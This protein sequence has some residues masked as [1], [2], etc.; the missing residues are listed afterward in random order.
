MLADETV[1]SP[2][3]TPRTTDPANAVASVLLAVDGPTWLHDVLPELTREGFHCVVDPTGESALDSDLVSAVDIAIVDLGL[4]HMSG[5]AVC[6]AFRSR[7]D[8]PIIAVV[9]VRDEGSVLDAF[10]AGADHV[11]LSDVSARQVIARMRAL[12]RRWPPG[13]GRAAVVPVG[14]VQL[15]DLDGALVHGRRVPL[16]REEYE[17]LRA[18]LQRPGRVVTRRELQGLGLGAPS[19]RSLDVVV[20]RL[21]QK[22]EAID[23]IRRIRAVRGVG[24]RFDA[25][26]CAPGP[27]GA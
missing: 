27:E 10:A 19:S 22:L 8:A 23:G 1:V 25:E 17:V 15:D 3:P 4:R 16:L 5:V 20:R 9:G 26:G 13:T 7:S 24:F 6:A 18:L 2:P 14:P 12:L 11:A 21:R